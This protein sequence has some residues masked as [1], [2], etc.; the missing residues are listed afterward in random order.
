MRTHERPTSGIC[1]DCGYRFA[2]IGPTE[3]IA[4][5]LDLPTVYRAALN[6]PDDDLRRTTDADGWTAIEYAAHAA[7]VLHSTRKRLVLVFER[8]DRPVSPP[9]LEAVRAS[10]RGA[11]PELVLASVS[12]ACRDL[13]QLVGGVPDS[14]WDHTARIGD[15]TDGETL[16]ARELLSDA[17]HEAQHHALDARAVSGATTTGPVLLAP[18]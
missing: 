4:V 15:R 2:P 17:L 16:T 14:V 3:A 11:Q 9:H 5:L 10:A 12:A 13:A 6:A 8:D 1:D 7:E 18:A